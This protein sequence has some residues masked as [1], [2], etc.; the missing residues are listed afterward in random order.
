MLQTTD[1]LSLFNDVYDGF[2]AARFKSSVEA[3]NAELALRLMNRSYKTK[4]RKTKRSGREFVIM[5]VDAA[6]GP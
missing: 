4:I 1:I 3:H 2:K 6:N 5:L